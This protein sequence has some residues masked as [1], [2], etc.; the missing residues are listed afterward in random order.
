M[1]IIFFLFGLIVGSFLNVVV[2]RIRTAETILGR[3]HCTHCKKTIRWYDNIPVLS[4]VLLKFKCRECGK[5]ISWQYPLVELFT[6]IVFAA[7]ASQY[8]RLEDSSTWLITG[9]MLF[10]V[11][12]LFVIFVYDVLY[13]EIPNLV[14]WPAVIL[15]FS[16]NFILDF[17][18]EFSTVWERM[19]VSGL[20][21]GGGAFLF[22]FSLAFFSKEKWMGM[23]DAYLVILLGLILG[24]PKIIL[25]LFLAFAIGAA[26][27]MIL[28]GLKKKGMK[29]QLPFAP[30]L[31]AGAFIALFYYNPII[32]WYLGLF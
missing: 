3:S 21:A 9:V 30:F 18:Q 8:F 2:Y 6:G 28:I 4:F 10:L 13:M 32:V 12:A 31:I 23:G 24:W 11:S 26:Y 25:G 22:F 17:G 20:L 5:K 1:L 27:G 19:S 29:S 7:L 15:A 14:L 16:F